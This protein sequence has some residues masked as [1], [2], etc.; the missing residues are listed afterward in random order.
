MVSIREKGIQGSDN[1]T[2]E[3]SVEGGSLADARDRTRSVGL[4]NQAEGD[5]VQGALGGAEEVD[6]TGSGR[7]QG[8]H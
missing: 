7:D 5:P 2:A 4:K 3:G 1:N 8:H 6:H